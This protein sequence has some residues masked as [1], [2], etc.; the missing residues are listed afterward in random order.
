MIYISTKL[1]LCELLLSGCTTASDHHYVFSD[2]TKNAID[3]QM[4]A[5]NELGIRV[6]LTRG[7][8]SLGKKDGGLPPQSVIQDEKTIIEDS[9]RLI[10]KYHQQEEGAMNQIVLAPCSPFSVSTDL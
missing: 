10:K 1:A 6:V 4:K 5:A 7:S 8:M 2:K 9:I 3:I